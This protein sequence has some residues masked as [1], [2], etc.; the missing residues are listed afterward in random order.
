MKHERHYEVKQFETPMMRCGTTYNYYLICTQ[1]GVTKEQSSWYAYETL[2]RAAERCRELNEKVYI[3]DFDEE[4]IKD[5]YN[6]IDF[7]PLYDKIN[8][9]I[10]LQLTYKHE[11]EKSRENYRIKIESNEN[12]ADMFQIIKAAWKEFR[13]TTFST[14]I[15]PDGESRGNL[16]FWCTIQYS[17]KH[18][19][20]GSNG[21]SILEARY[22]SKKGWDIMTEIERQ[23]HLHNLID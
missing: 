9:T 4:E 20:G 17:Y 7:Q 11:L 8:K 6:S 10:G 22:S 13:V 16:R 23:E 19:N 18:Q 2:E 14:Q 15:C 21:A 12:I 1:D 3:S 5:F